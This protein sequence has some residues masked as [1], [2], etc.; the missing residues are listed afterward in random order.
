ML[1]ISLA[2][3]IPDDEI[4]L[5][6]IRSQGAGGQN[7]NKVSSAI[8]LRFDI[9]ASSL[10]EVYKERLLALR[11]KR[12]TKEGVIVI[13]AQQHRTQEKNRQDAL[14]RLQALIQSVTVVQKVRRA[15]KPTK[16]SQKRRLDSKTKRSH[17]KKM[18]GRIED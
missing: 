13:K 15:T 2:V 11:D 6:A 17:L 8:H 10:P 3:S 4:E 5:S 7:V 14:N 1:K 12:L 9:M 18:R 16:G